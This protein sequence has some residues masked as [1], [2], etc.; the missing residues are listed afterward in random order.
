MLTSNTRELQQL[1]LFLNSIIE[2]IPHMIF[3]KEASSLKCPALIDS[4]VGARPFLRGG[5]FF[6]FCGVAA[7]CGLAEE[8]VLCLDPLLPVEGRRGRF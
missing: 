6:L 2:N 4:Y 5:Y 8:C 3:I 1:N 7:E